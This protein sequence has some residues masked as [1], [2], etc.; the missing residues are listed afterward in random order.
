MTLPRIALAALLA[1]TPALAEEKDSRLTMTISE[2]ERPGKI[3]KWLGETPHFV[4]EGLV[5]PY[6]FGVYFNDIQ[7]A[8]GIETYEATRKYRASDDGPVF[9]EFEMSLEAEIEGITKTLQI[10]FSGDDL[11]QHELPTDL[12]LEGQAFPEGASAFMNV[13]FDWEIGEDAV[14]VQMDGWIGFLAFTSNEGTPDDQGMA[15]DGSIGGL[16]FSSYGNDIILA[17][18][19]VPV[20]SAELIE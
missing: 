5:A 8:N 17:S 10:S 9:A 14:D 3:D 11:S 13:E 15:A 6:G 4:M 19:T 1:V 7:A 2:G 20:T 18:F 16:I 12:T